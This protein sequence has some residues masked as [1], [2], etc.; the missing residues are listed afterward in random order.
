MMN[1]AFSPLPASSPAWAA[2]ASNRAATPGALAGFSANCSTSSA[3][4]AFASGTGRPTST[5]ATAA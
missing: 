2:D 4:S 5:A 3:A 1:W